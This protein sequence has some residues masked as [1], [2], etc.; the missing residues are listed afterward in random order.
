MRKSTKDIQMKKSLGN[1]LV[2]FLLF[3]T[4]SEAK[5]LASYVITSNKTEVYEKEAF[6]I[7]F[8]AK[9][10]DHTDN[11]MFLVAPKKSDD[12]KAILLNKK[13]NDKKY[14]DTQ[15]SYTYLLFPL[16]AK[17][18][19]V[20]FDF[21]IQTAS[22]K[23][24]ANSYVDDHDDSIAI[25]TYNTKVKIKPFTMKVKKLQKKVDLV[26]DFTL[27][28]HIQNTKINQYESINISYILEGVGYEDA[29]IEPIKSIK[30]VTIFSEINDIYSRYTQ[31]GD[32]FK[33][34]YIYALSAKENFT[35]PQVTLQA[36]SPK[37]KKYYTLTTPIHT[38]KVTKIDPTLLLDKDEYPQT[39]SLINIDALKNFFIYIIIFVSG[40]LSA[41]FQSFP[42]KPKQH[43][44]EFLEIKDAKTAK[45]LLFIL[46]SKYKNKFSQETKILEDIVYNNA[47]YNFEKLKTKIL[48]ELS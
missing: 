20:D 24:I 42:F 21:T 2:V 43:S 26:G 45:K 1:I 34:E 18:I 29:D 27:K 11:M 33:R 16:K 23:A 46:V 7:T 44:K 48:K 35:I 12:Y 31:K 5:D 25:Q 39:T 9:Q 17:K 3:L 38:I 15:T 13:I 22:N 28:E 4:N 36:Y 30:N 40:F 41:K 14:H 37:T 8:N 6:T 10:K 47:S 32:T 19:S